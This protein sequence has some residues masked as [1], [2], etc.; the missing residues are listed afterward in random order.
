MGSAESSNQNPN[1]KSVEIYWNPKG[2]V[3]LYVDNSSLY[4]S[5]Q[6]HA[7]KVQGFPAGVN[8]VTCR[9][10]LHTLIDRVVKGR[11]VLVRKAYGITSPEV[12]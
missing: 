9:M 6:A 4:T 11:N 10:H 5:T 8:D 12:E 3:L 7:G 2:R 1:S